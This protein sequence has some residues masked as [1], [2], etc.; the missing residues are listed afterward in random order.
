MDIAVYYQYDSM[1]YV[2]SFHEYVEYLQSNM[3]L[4]F[5]QIVFCIVLMLQDKSQIK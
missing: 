4:Q 5:Y 2:W 3:F 1:L